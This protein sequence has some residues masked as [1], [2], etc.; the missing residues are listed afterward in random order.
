MITGR[1]ECGEVKY[2]VDAE[3]TDFSH[4]HCSQC[5]RLHGAAFASFAGVSRE[6][7]SFE[8]EVSHVASY[9]SSKTHARMFCRHCG[10]NILVELGSEPDSLYLA[11]GT[12]DGIPALPPGYHIYVGSKA[13]WHTISDDL[14]QYE[15]E[16]ED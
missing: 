8:T 16:P 13:P 14:P 10:S 9:A 6:A 4:C 12:M 15:T 7:F 2:R 1:C 3:I 5:R 11:M